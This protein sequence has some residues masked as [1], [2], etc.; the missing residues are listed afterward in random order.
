MRMSSV[1]VL[2][3]STKQKGKQETEGKTVLDDILCYG[4]R[5]GEMTNERQYV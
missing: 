2:G 3:K 1:V 5:T 4:N